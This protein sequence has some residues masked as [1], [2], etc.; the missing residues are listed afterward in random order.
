MRHPPITVRQ[1]CEA[2]SGSGGATMRI[3]LWAMLVASPIS[4]APASAQLEQIGK[5]LGLGSKT[6]LGDTKI[7]SG[8]KEALK[9]GAEGPK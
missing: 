5:A 7:A 4:C 1:F 6:Q 8:L 2:I 9:V 3:R